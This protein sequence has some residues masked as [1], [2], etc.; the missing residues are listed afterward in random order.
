[1]E[2]ISISDTMAEHFQLLPIVNNNGSEKDASHLRALN[3]SPHPSIVSQTSQTSGTNCSSPSN[4][5]TSNG[6]VGIEYQKT[7][8]GW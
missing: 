1:M 4:V 5:Y 2:S 3:L 8:A 7:H 6:H